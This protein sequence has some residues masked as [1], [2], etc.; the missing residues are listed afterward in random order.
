MPGTIVTENI[1][2]GG[3]DKRDP[4]LMDLNLG[5]LYWGVGMGEQQGKWTT[6]K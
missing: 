2:G 4:D 6:S 1:G 3:E 5:E